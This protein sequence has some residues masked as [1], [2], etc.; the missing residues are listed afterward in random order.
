MSPAPPTVEDLS[1]VLLTKNGGTLLQHVLESLIGCDGIEQVELLCIDSG[2]SDGTI[3]RLARYP[4]IRLVQIPPDEFGHGRT[5]NLAV[6]L[7]TRPNVAFLVQDASPAGPGFLDRLLQ[8]LADVRVAGVY[9]RQVA[10]DSAT[11]VE[12][13]FL[14]ST[15]PQV[16]R[17]QQAPSGREMTVHDSFFSNVAAVIR[18]DVLL[19]IPYRE[20]VVMSEDAFWCRAALEQGWAV[21]YAADAV[22]WHSHSYALR[23]VF[24]RNFDTGASVASELGGRRR[25]LLAYELDHLAR[26][27]AALLRGGEAHWLPYFAAHEVVRSMGVGLGSQWRRL[28]QRAVQ[29]MSLHGYHWLRRY[30]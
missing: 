21:A 10:R 12:R 26:G 15:Y 2:S 30:S 1:L 29:K 14:N 16:A 9:G 3:E 22:V 23:D 13:L 4:Q 24:R 17:R 27:S 6:S 5:R 8:P 11:P 28:P 7:C 18:R 19:A 25:D 20:D